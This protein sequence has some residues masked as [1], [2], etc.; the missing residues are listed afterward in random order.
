MG[1]ASGLAG[2]G[3]LARGRVAA[4]ELPRRGRD[5]PAAQETYALISGATSCRRRRCDE[6]G[7]RICP[8]RSAPA[9]ASAA[10]VPRRF[11]PRG[12]RVRPPLFLE[13][14]LL[15]AAAA[16]LPRPAIVAQLVTLDGGWRPINGDSSH[17]GSKAG[18]VLTAIL[19][20]FEAAGYMTRWRLLSSERWARTEA[21][22]VGIVGIRSDLDGS[23]PRCPLRSAE[24]ESFGSWLA[25]SE[26]DLQASRRTRAEDVARATLTV[27]LA[28][29]VSRARWP[30]SSV[31][32]LPRGGRPRRRHAPDGG[33]G[34]T[35]SSSRWGHRPATMPCDERRWRHPRPSRTRPSPRAGPPPTSPRTALKTD[36][37]GTR[38]YHNRAT[39]ETTWTRPSG[40]VDPAASAAPTPEPRREHGGSTARPIGGPSYFATQPRAPSMDR[41]S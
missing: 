6:N 38:Y 13:L 26:R 3:G 36:D 8:T 23:M 2:I 39:N 29:L 7:R 17:E 24:R 15:V 35:S 9:P 21:A 14:A 31:V 27:V 34:R 40:A 22:S 28:R 16:R 5:V 12:R 37:G 11:R 33:A 32:R 20:A 18:G 41:P 10:F 4:P 30:V 1:V 25:R 19:A